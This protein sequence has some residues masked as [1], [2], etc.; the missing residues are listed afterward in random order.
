MISPLFRDWHKVGMR[1]AGSLPTSNVKS[2]PQFIVI[3]VDSFAPNIIRNKNESAD[4]QAANTAKAQG[5]RRVQENGK[6][7]S[8]A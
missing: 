2:T 8:I 4:T 6:S 3:L 7:T 5:N 1:V